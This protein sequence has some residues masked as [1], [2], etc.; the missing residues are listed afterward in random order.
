M[1]WLP[2]ASVVVIPSVA[3]EAGNHPR[4]I[5]LLTTEMTTSKD[6]F[7]L[8]EEN[9]ASPHLTI[10]IDSGEIYQHLPFSAI[11]EG[12]EKIINNPLAD[13]E[14]VAVG[15]IGQSANVSSYPSA[16]LSNLGNLLFDLISGFLISGIAPKFHGTELANI[17]DLNAPQRFSRAQWQQFSGICG[18]QHVPEVN[19]WDPGALDINKILSERQP[20]VG[21][22]PAFKAPLKKNSKNSLVGVWQKALGIEQTGRFDAATIQAT[23]EFQESV[24]LE[25]TG[26]VDELTWTTAAASFSREDVL[27]PPPS[28]SLQLGSESPFVARW[29]SFLQ[30]SPDGIFGPSTD[31]ATRKFQ[32]SLQIQATGIVDTETWSKARFNS[33]QD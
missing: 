7:K 28:V 30:I 19:R 27:G 22:L 21:M 23:K 8:Y 15:I 10:A 5:V 6:S 3:S 12:S 9:K 17:L 4:R 1:D 18:M 24:N 11:S 25:V 26:F 33:L 29:Q 20:S 32:E 16:W 2:N 13:G 31:Q 14:T